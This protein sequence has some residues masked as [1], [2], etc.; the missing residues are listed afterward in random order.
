[1]SSNLNDFYKHL[2]QN[3]DECIM[4]DKE[5]YQFKGGDQFMAA[6]FL[7]GLGVSLVG[8]HLF[9]RVGELTKFNLRGNF[10]NIIICNNFSNLKFIDIKI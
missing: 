3:P 10:L 9:G 4:S 6:K 7:T 5:L 1:M 8:I 2:T